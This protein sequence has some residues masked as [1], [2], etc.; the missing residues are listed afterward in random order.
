MAWNR[1]WHAPSAQDAQDQPSTSNATAQKDSTEGQQTAGTRT[2]STDKAPSEANLW[3]GFEILCHQL[4]C[5]G[6][7]FRGVTTASAGV[8]EVVPTLH[9]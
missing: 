4:R 5:W 9:A 2:A 8:L 7:E 6:K 3:R 1:R